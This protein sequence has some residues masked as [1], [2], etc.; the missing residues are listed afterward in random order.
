[1]IIPINSDEFATRNSSAEDEKLKINS[2]NNTNLLNGESHQSSKT[3]GYY[4]SKRIKKFPINLN[5]NETINQSYNKSKGIKE[6]EEDNYKKLIATL[7]KIAKVQS[8]GKDS[9]TSEQVKVPNVSV[10][11]GKEPTFLDT[12]SSSRSHY[13]TSDTGVKQR[14]VRCYAIPKPAYI[15]EIN[16]FIF[17]YACKLKNKIFILS[18]KRFFEDRRT[19]VYVSIDDETLDKINSPATDAENGKLR[20]ISTTLALQKPGHNY[21]VRNQENVTSR[22]EHN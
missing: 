17:A 20:I 16:E 19:S 22:E 15:P 14:S 13:N 9:S 3:T 2:T 12:K 1:M 5:N 8:T 6:K 4:L 18:S 10:K 11:N 21:Y 7:S